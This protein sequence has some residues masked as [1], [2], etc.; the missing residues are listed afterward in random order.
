[1][2]ELAFVR[3]IGDDSF[4]VS[5]NRIGARKLKEIAMDITRGSELE[6]ETDLSNPDMTLP[7]MVALFQV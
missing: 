1:M 5:R 2:V 4:H 6:E 7:R 3:G